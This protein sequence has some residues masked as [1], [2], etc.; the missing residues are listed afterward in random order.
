MGFSST[1]IDIYAAALM[2]KI[3]SIKKNK[4]LGGRSLS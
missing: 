4:N 2:A 1:V 3:N